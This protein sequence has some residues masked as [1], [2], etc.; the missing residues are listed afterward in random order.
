MVSSDGSA[1]TAPALV[2]SSRELAHRT[3]AT[4]S[5]PYSIV[6]TRERVLAFAEL[7]GADHWMHLDP[8]RAAA[9][10]LGRATVPGLLTLSL[11]ALL[12]PHVLQ[13]GSSDAVFYGFDRVRFPAPMFIGD[14]LRLEAEI[15]SA[16]DLG[17]SVQAVVRHR[18]WSAGPKPVCVAEQKIRYTHDDQR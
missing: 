3:G 18:F 17:H 14:R 6:V 10:T 2:I 4:F 12:E 5:S 11:G 16:D 13:V 15:L 8:D 9:S 1:A 7:T